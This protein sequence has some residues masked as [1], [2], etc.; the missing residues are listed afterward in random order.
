MR[1][2]LSIA[3]AAALC[4]GVAQPC[5]AEDPDYGTEITDQFE[6]TK[7]TKAKIEALTNY[8][9]QATITLVFT[10]KAT[11]AMVGTDDAWN[12]GYGF[13]AIE[14]IKKYDANGLKYTDY[15]ARIDLNN[16]VSVND[17]IVVTYT[18]QQLRQ[19]I[20]GSPTGEKANDNDK[21]FEINIWGSGGNKPEVWKAYYKEAAAGAWV[22]PK[23]CEEVI[24]TGDGGW[25]SPTYD[26]ATK[27]YT[28]AEADKDSKGCGL[29]AYYGDGKA[30][31]WS[32]YKQF[33]VEFTDEEMNGGKVVI[34]SDHK[35]DGRADVYAQANISKGKCTVDLTSVTEGWKVTQIFEQGF[36]GTFG[37]KGMY[38]VP[39][40]V[41]PGDAL[42]PASATTS[43]PVSATYY[44]LTG[45]QVAPGTK[46]LLIKATKTADGKTKATKVIVK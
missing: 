23:G 45:A 18:F 43:A 40:G 29:V 25:S 7:L 16:G 36:A 44:D 4:A 3:C 39:V 9:E 11:Q 30:Q 33:V 12:A 14:S 5:L 19:I 32:A 15:P 31:D 28:V 21:G 41:E 22:L 34:N 17:P 20:A 37:V 10:P 2:L 46:G 8:T 1:N 24:F 38:L 13:G 42:T 35:T 26:A 6:G 27:E